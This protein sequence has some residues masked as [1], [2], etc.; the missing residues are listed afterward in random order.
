MSDR[1]IAKIKRL[2]HDATAATVEQDLA[3]A[4]EI[5]KTLPDRTHGPE[6]LSLWMGC[7]RCGQ[8][9]G[10]N[11]RTGQEDDARR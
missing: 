8:S 4:V 11:R 3:Q 1:K 5:L 9:G 10:L 7:P 6:P 2:Y